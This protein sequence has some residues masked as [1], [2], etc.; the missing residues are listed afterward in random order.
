MIDDPCSYLDLNVDP[1]HDWTLVVKDKGRAQGLDKYI[2][3]ISTIALVGDDDSS[4]SQLC[5]PLLQKHSLTYW[6]GSDPDTP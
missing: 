2:A 5:R 6:L 3:C 1:E 4:F